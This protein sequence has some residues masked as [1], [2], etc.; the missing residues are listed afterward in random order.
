MLDTFNRFHH[1]SQLCNL[2]RLSPHCNNL[3]AVVMI[4]M[5]VLG[6]NDYLLKIV[7]EIRNLVEQ[8]FPWWS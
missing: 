7:L 4:Q 2:P 1:V 8:V 6:R 3:K 5:D